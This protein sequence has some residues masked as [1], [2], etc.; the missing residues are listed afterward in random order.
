MEEKFASDKKELVGEFPTEINTYNN[1][2]LPPHLVEEITKETGSGREN[3][4]KIKAVYV[5]IYD[6]TKN[7]PEPRRSRKRALI[8]TFV[9]Q[10]YAYDKPP[11][12]P[13]HYRIKG[14]SS[15][16][17]KGNRIWACGIP[18]AGKASYKR[19]ACGEKIDEFVIAIKNLYVDYYSHISALAKKDSCDDCDDDDI[20]STT[21]TDDEKTIVVAADYRKP[22]ISAR[23]TLIESPP[24]SQTVEMPMDVISS[25]PP[26]QISQDSMMMAPIPMPPLM[27]S[28]KSSSIA[29]SIAAAQE[30]FVTSQKARARATTEAFMEI[31]D[32]IGQSMTRNSDAACVNAILAAP[33][34][35]PVAISYS[36]PIRSG[37]LNATFSRR[38]AAEDLSDSGGDECMESRSEMLDIS[39]AAFLRGVLK[40][41]KDHKI[42]T[43]GMPLRSATRLTVIFSSI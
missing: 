17:L 14:R 8:S 4:H 29:A 18:S 33:N 41:A 3:F 23:Q 5:H 12:E 38:S 37:L 35:S 6:P 7:M 42:D 11:V 9:A 36:V 39:T 40:I 2:L 13:H 21:T 26:Q 34:T 16:V 31:S 15:T 32:E 28:Q 19:F 30:A 25:S 24:S 10:L 20:S 1:Y 22:P 27:L 43:R